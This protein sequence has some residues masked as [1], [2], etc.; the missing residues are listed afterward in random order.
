[1][2]SGLQAHLVV[3]RDN[4]FALDVPLEIAPGHT[5]ALLGPNGA[6]KST[7]VSLLAGLLP[8]DT[9]RISLDGRTLDD[10]TG[11]VFVPPERGG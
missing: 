3:G 5:V 7:V 11:N 2:T 4:G 1:M 10:P 8:L 9:G 6:G